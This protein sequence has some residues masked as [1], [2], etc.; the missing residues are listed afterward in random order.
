MLQIRTKRSRTILIFSGVII[1]SLLL[2]FY[3]SRNGLTTL[4]NPQ[5]YQ[6]SRW[7]LSNYGLS[8]FKVTSGDGIH[9][10][11]DRARWYGTLWDFFLGINTEYLLKF[12]HDP[13]WVRH[14]LSIALFP[15]S[16]FLTF[17]LLLR[18]QVQ[19]STALLA[20][21]M[22]YSMIRLG[23]HTIETKDFPV[24]II[25]PLISIYIWVKLREEQQNSPGTLRIRTLGT[26][27]A[28][29]LIPFLLRPPLILHFAII[30]ALAL[31]Y[32]LRAKHLSGRNVIFISVLPLILGIGIYYI[33]F[34]A[35]WGKG[36]IEWLVPFFL[37]VKFPH[38]EPQRFFGGI[39]QPN[40]MPWWYS[41]GWTPVIM[42]ILT[43]IL[44]ILGLIYVLVKH[45][46][47]GA[48]R[49]QLPGLPLNFSLPAWMACISAL[50]WGAV[51]ILQPNLYGGLRHILFLYPII[52]ITAALGLD[53][54]KQ[55][56]KTA[57][58]VALIVISTHA[59]ATWG[60]YSYIYTPSTLPYTEISLSGGDMRNV[61]SAEAINYIM[62]NTTD[63]SIVQT[64][65]LLSELQTTRYFSSIF[66]TNATKR[67][68][69]LVSLG[70][71]DSNIPSSYFK[72]TSVRSTQKEYLNL[73]DDVSEGKA[74]IVWQRTLPTNEE[75]CLVSLYHKM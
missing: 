23:G 51:L 66:Y 19:K 57:L 7:L 17:A 3:A 44:L 72:I 14:A 5:R 27:T 70:T 54:L 42:P 50:S 6:C 1:S 74:H 53:S 39:Y 64:H 73:M 71:S 60:R 55:H 48:P 62:D 31:C 47:S 63:P 36:L 24:A 38:I 2:G 33:S 34:P 56:I 28:I 16:L 20:V 12:F 35:L 30:Q 59:Y 58:I 40:A 4:D 10:C 15:F 49:L 46:K 9:E 41:L 32:A 43:F 29:S 61:C 22:L 11:S 37:F 18:A 68:L 8:D 21:A 52:L 75:V 26:L 65:S 69:K 45:T 67:N 13:Q 25:F